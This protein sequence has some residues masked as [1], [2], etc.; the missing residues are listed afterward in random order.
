MTFWFDANRNSSSTTVTSAMNLTIECT[1][2]GNYLLVHVDGEWTEASARRIVD[3][4]LDLTNEHG[5]TR[6]LLD[7]RR[8]SRPDRDFTRYVSGKYIAETLGPRIR[9]AAIGEPA[10]V[11]H[12]AETVALNRGAKLRAFTS[13]EAALEWLLG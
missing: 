10:N 13:E 4:I 5:T 8:L 12:Y 11:T 6:V 7:S 1:D 3:V 9:V 2:R